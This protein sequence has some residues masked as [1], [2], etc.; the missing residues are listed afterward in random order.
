MQCTKGYTNNGTKRKDREIGE[1]E[2]KKKQYP[3]PK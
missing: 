1:N 3:N 2:K